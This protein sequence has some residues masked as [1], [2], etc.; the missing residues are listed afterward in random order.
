[1][2]KIIL[3][4]QFVITVIYTFEDDIKRDISGDEDF[5]LRLSYDE[6]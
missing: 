6:R 1:M 2:N 3:L 4:A 5:S